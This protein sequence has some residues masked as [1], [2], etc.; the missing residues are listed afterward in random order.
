MVLSQVQIKEHNGDHKGSKF[1]YGP[2]MFNKLGFIIGDPKIKR[3]MGWKS[4]GRRDRPEFPPVELFSLVWRSHSDRSHDAVR[5]NT[6]TCVQVTWLLF[7]CS[8]VQLV[9]LPL[10]TVWM[11]LKVESLFKTPVVCII[12]I[13]M[14]TH[15]YVYIFFF[16]ESFFFLTRRSKCG[17][18]LCCWHIAEP[19]HPDTLSCKY[20]QQCII[21]FS[22]S[23]LP[24][25]KLGPVHT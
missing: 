22:Y 25:Q 1:P 5:E 8:S 20:T 16:I 10:C 18:F 24:F 12:H 17:M 4:P 6:S 14:Y 7:D 19:H 13:C 11:L 15:M 2:R 21:P 9:S 3:F 23:L